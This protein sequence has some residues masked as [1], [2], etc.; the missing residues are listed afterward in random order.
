VNILDNMRETDSTIQA[1]GNSQAKS[2]PS[3][4]TVP[5]A[6]WAMRQ[7]TRE[8]Q[9][10]TLRLRNNLPLSLLCPSAQANYRTAHRCHANSS[11]VALS[12]AHTRAGWARFSHRSQ[13]STG[14]PFHFGIGRIG[15]GAIDA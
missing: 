6:G 11:R 9:M 3:F 5:I 7:I 13:I 8:K 1:F 12:L 2:I 15:S 4:R 10:E 14:Y